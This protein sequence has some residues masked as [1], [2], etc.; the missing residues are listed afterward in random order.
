[1]PSVHGTRLERWLGSA[2]VERISSAMRDWYGPPIPIARVPGRVMAMPGGDF[3][4]KLSAGGFASLADLAAERYKRFLRRA[5]RTQ[6][7]TLFTG[8]AS[9]SDLIAE[10]TA[11]KR[12]EFPFQKA[13]ATGVVGVTNSLW[14]LGNQPAAGVNAS[15]APGGDAPT[16]LTTGAFPFDNPS[17]PDTQ[18]FVSGY[19]LASVAGNTLLLYDRIFQVNKTMNSTGTEAVTG[20]PTRYQSTTPGAED[21]AG[22]NFLFVEIGGTALAATAHNWTAC[23]YTDQDGN[24]GAALPSLTGHGRFLRPHPEGYVSA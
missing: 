6:R 22:G 17:S 20:V 10:A 15:N 1:M 23:L 5:V 14:G 3:S 16:D 21:Y 12:R 19:P 24:T 18:H 4:G 11:G 2:E 8:F 13:G 9:L 7:S